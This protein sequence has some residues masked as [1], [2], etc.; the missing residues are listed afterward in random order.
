MPTFWSRLRRL[1][2]GEQR[3]RSAHRTRLALEALEH[4]F[5]PAAFFFQNSFGNLAIALDRGESLIVFELGGVRSFELCGA[6]RW[7]NEGPDRPSSSFADTI[8]FD[9]SR[10][11][12]G[13]LSIVGESNENNV[14]FA[15]GT[16]NF[17]QVLVDLSNGSHAEGDIGFA[18]A[19]TN[20]TGL[21]SVQMHAG[22]TLLQTAPVT[23]NAP[24]SFTTDADALN[25]N[26]PANDFR[27]PVSVN[28]L[29]SVGA[30]LADANDLNVFAVNLG[31]GPLNIQAGGTVTFT[32]PWQVNL[33]KGGPS[34]LVTVTAAAVNL[35]G[36]S[37]TGT[38]NGFL[39]HDQVLLLNN[40]SAPPI[41]GGFTNGSSLTLGSSGFQ[42]GVNVGTGNNDVVLTSNGT[43][44]Q[45]Y[46]ANLYS[47]LLERPVDPG[48]LT[49][50]SQQ[51]D[52]GVSRQQVSASI[53]ASDEYLI[54]QITHV[55]EWYLFRAPDPLGLN[56][57]LA[58]L[59]SGGNV[60]DMKL[61][62]LGSAEYFQVRGGSTNTGFLTALYN[63]L[64]GRAP[65]PVGLNDFGQQL[66][67]GVPRT[68]IAHVIYLSP[69]GLTRLINYFYVRYLGRSVDALGLQNNSAT[70]AAGATEEFVINGL[71][72]SQ[73]FYDRPLL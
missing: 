57:W 17:N 11:L 42:I 32:G 7:F 45:I 60:R 35:Y 36:A 15:G 12:T 47:V 13:T 1:V 48:G 37:L 34:T 8:S 14:D 63:D 50:W 10:N 22:G 23:M 62:L 2:G 27:G 52:H 73:E 9:A 26:N 70:M 6:G 53:M 46:V 33:N 30:S 64:L 59:K 69:E 20:F 19:T 68:T 5:A 21:G 71:V 43:R 40:L 66:D 38:A 4:R 41:T 25:L 49:S 29:G 67:A 44:N 58:Y 61:N 39:I 18:T 24:A 3:P 65:D 16:F 55:Y 31:T 72:S 51:L 28:N 56:N 54:L